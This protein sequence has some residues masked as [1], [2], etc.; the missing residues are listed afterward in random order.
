MSEDLVKQC[1]DLP[2]EDRQR[3]IHHLV[4]SLQVKPVYN[5]QYCNRASFLRCILE[6][7]YGERLT[8]DNRR[9][10]NVWAKAMIVYQMV[11]EGYTTIEIGRQIGL[12]HPAVINLRNKMTDAISL[13]IA[14]KDIIDIWK[15][16]QNKL[17]DEIHK[18]T[19]EHPVCLGG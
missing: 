14:Y 8:F 17:Q 16:F 9:K 7:I 13:K 3:L 1:I 10:D 4:D 18:G 6:N 11:R 12:K 5:T 19:T 15:Q 2:Y